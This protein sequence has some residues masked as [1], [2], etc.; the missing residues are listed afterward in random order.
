MTT[1]L[2]S[3]T[4][5]FMAPREDGGGE[6]E[7]PR[8]QAANDARQNFIDEMSSVF[9]EILEDKSNIKPLTYIPAGTRI[10]VYPNVDLW[11]R[12]ID[13]DK[14]QQA[15]RKKPTDILLDPGAAK[16]KEREAQSTQVK[17]NSVNNSEVVYEADGGDA[18]AQNTDTLISSSSAKKDK[19]KPI[20]GYVPPPPPPSSGAF[21]SQKP[22]TG[23]SSNSSSSNSNDGVPALF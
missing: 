3:A 15:M 1:S 23:G 13:L 22:V 20:Q 14:E 11:V 4:S 2:S 19:P 18:K 12:S 5:Y 17:S 10:V 8:Q 6:T 7:S 21:P 9:D 16:N